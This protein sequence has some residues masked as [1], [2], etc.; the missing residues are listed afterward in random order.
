MDAFATQFMKTAQSRGYS[1]EQAAGL[2][3][4]ARINQ[5][6]QESPA[7]AAAFDAHMAKEAWGPKPLTPEWYTKNINNPEE[8]AKHESAQAHADWV[9]KQQAATGAKMPVGNRGFWGALMRREKDP[10]K[11]GYYTDNPN[12]VEN[13]T[14]YERYLKGQH[15]DKYTP[16]AQAS[17]ATPAGTVWGAK[18]DEL[19]NKA[20]TNPAAL[21]PAQHK[22][23]SGLWKTRSDRE[24]H[25]SQWKP[26]P[27]ASND[28]YAAAR[29]ARR[30]SMRAMR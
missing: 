11:P 23:L 21:T 14:G 16:R 10:T 30:Y 17:S 20:Q 3:K 7:F 8:I 12:A 22:E 28:P 27:P 29:A 15:A 4:L 25:Y 5:R 2:L 6:R 24:A 1:A 13:M 18:H 26:K 9:A 19:W